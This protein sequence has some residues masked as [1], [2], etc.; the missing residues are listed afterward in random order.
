MPHFLKFIDNCHINKF[1]KYYDIDSNE[2]S[3]E[4]KKESEECVTL[5]Y[6]LMDRIMG[7]TEISFSGYGGIAFYIEKTRNN[8]IIRSHFKKAWATAEDASFG[9]KPI[10]QSTEEFTHE[11]NLPREIYKYLAYYKMIGSLDKFKHKLQQEILK[12]I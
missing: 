8:G 6:K 10:S 11:Y 2:C 4:F 1:K 7:S 5:I 12:L 3:D 9:Y